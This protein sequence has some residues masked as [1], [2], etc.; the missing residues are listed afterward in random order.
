M[1]KKNVPNESEAIRAS[2]NFFSANSAGKKF[3]NQ[4]VSYLGCPTKAISRVATRTKR[5]ISHTTTHVILTCCS[6][7]TSLNS[8]DSWAPTLQPRWSPSKR[9]SQIA[10]T[11][12]TRTGANSPCTPLTGRRECSTW[13]CTA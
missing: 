8:R 12:Q 6:I 9:T 2:G 3:A 7:H 5:S 13:T 11:R 4:Y 1:D 10:A